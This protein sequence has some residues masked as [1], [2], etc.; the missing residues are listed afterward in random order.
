MEFL[1]TIFGGPALGLLGSLGTGVLQF[2]GKKGDRVHEIALLTLQ[3]EQRSADQ[4]NELLIAQADAA[5]KSVSSS[6]RHDMALAKRESRWV[7]NIKALTRPLLTWALVMIVAAMFFK[8]VQV[9][10]LTPIREQI[11]V[12]VLFLMEVAVTWWFGDRAR[13]AVR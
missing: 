7:T 8:N 13:V 5:A 12:A 9:A 3:G 6:M 1:A 4:E 11:V 10:D 2:M